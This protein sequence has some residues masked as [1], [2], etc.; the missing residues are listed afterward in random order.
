MDEWCG[1]WIVKME[2]G[3]KKSHWIQFLIDSPIASKHFNDNSRINYNSSVV[4]SEALIEVLLNINWTWT[5]TI[6]RIKVNNNRVIHSFN[7]SW[8]EFNKLLLL[9]FSLQ[10][11]LSCLT[12]L[13][14]FLSHT[15]SNIM[16]Q[17]FKHTS[18]KFVLFIV[19]TIMFK[20]II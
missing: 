19:I 6:N 16:S 20:S 4:K 9:N 8:S 12:I 5:C 10:V 13:S 2:N 7:S 11:F 3:V 15:L 14:Q 17:W 1:S 18:T